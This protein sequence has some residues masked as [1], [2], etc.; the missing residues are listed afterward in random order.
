MCVYFREITGKRGADPKAFYVT[1]WSSAHPPK[2]HSNPQRRLGPGAHSDTAAPR[3]LW[4]VDSCAVTTGVW[5]QDAIP[6][7][8]PRLPVLPDSS[9]KGHPG[10]P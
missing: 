3:L 9:L 6:G 8:A 5:A 2:G 4:T 10:K 1:P 7:H